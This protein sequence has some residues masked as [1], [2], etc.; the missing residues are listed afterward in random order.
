VPDISA[1][2]GSRNGI[3]VQA[4]LGRK[5]DPISKTTK[6]NKEKTETE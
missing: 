6:E 5:Q 4:G 1:T 2:W 3:A